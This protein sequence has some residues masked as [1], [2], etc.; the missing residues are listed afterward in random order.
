RPTRHPP[1]LHRRAL[2]PHAVPL[3]ARRRNLPHRP[4]HHAPHLPRLPARCHRRPPH[5]HR[6]LHRR[7]VPPR[8]RSPHR[9]LAL[10]RSA[11]RLHRRAPHTRLVRLLDRQ[12][13]PTINARQAIRRRHSALWRRPRPTHHLH[14]PR[15]Q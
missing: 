11:R 14:P 12:A 10:P 9:A 8:P 5:R 7:R 4:A 2:P 6:R 13:P 1:P 15:A 3:H